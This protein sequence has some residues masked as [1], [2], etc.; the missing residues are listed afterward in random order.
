MKSPSAGE[1]PAPVALVIPTYNHAHFLDD[2]IA[3]ILAQTRMP[4]E[5]IVIDDGSRDRPEAV[6]A[7]YPQ[8]RLMRQD[9]QGLAIARNSGL[10]ATQAP[11]LLFLDADDRLP[12]TA[13]ERG[14]AL[15]DQ[16]PDAA[17]AYG[18]YVNIY[19]PERRKAARYHP[20]PANAFAA[21]L[22]AN[23]VGMHGTVL[24]RRDPL[25][26]AGGFRSGLPA[27]EDYDLYL[28][29]ARDHPIV[30][31]PDLLA[32]YWH[33]G[34]NMSRD[35][36]MMLQWTLHVLDLQRDA[37]TQA[38]LDDDLRAGRRAACDHYLGDWI[39][40][41]RRQPWTWALIGQGARLA[42]RSPS[43]IARA[44]ARRIMPALMRRS[45]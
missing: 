26:A 24:Y 1:F 7:R 3:S 23:L 20:A 4:A 42:R 32:E 38:G 44:A 41:M 45:S 37:A 17:F 36:A 35:A 28:R 19:G 33:H 39:G 22:R 10:R 34:G 25:E 16:H 13:I 5:I 15:L 30:S 29:L 6:V 9:N 40:A 27:C 18:G 43:L 2:A 11:F 21:F 14:M 8:V 12:P 31:Q